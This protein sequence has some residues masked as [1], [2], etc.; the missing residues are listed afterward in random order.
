[1]KQKA[2]KARQDILLSKSNLNGPVDTKPVRLVRGVS[3]SG[4][5]GRPYI[6]PR[7]KNVSIRTTQLNLKRWKNPAFRR[8]MAKLNKRRWQDPIYYNKM[9]KANQDNKE[10]YRKE[11]IERWKN[12]E[13][14]KKMLYII[15]NCWGRESYRAK[16][17]QRDLKNS[18]R[19]NLMW[20]NPQF[21]NLMFSS[22]VR[23]KQSSSRKLSP[24]R[25]ESHA[26]NFINSLSRIK[27]KFVGGGTNAIII[28]GRSPDFI[29]KNKKIIVL[30][31]S[32]HWH[33][34]VY[35]LKN[36]IQNKRRAEKVDRKPFIKA[37]YR[38]IFMWDD[39]FKRPGYASRFL[40]GVK[41]EKKKE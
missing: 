28:N 20:E 16:L 25:T 32:I 8:K 19:F 26:L 34:D 9:Q 37:G 23:Q 41:N 6:S 10:K 27:F 12:P 30:F 7:Y 2:R 33:L 38:V 3:L 31:H 13:Y 24:N 18:K 40:D 11:L 22:V 21:R 15:N 14:R 29:N 17:K 36:T 5:Q 1:M 35:G 39:E 4:E